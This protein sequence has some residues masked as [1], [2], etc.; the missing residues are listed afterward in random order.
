LTRFAPAAPPAIELARVTARNFIVATAGHVDH[1]K[2][3]LVKALTGADP[4]RLPEEKARG[5]TIDLGFA[6]LTLN[7][8][9]GDTLHVGIVDVPGHEDF[10]KNMIAGVGSIDLALFVIAADDGWMPQTEDHLQILTYL[11]IEHAV[12]ALTKVDLTDATKTANVRKQ[13]IDTS[14]AHAPIVETS[15]VSG[16][17]LEELRATLAC[18][19]SSLSPQHDIG[20]PRLFVDRVFSLRGVGT[21]VTGTLGGG[22]LARSQNVIVQPRNISTRIRSIQSHNREQQEIGPGT[23]TALN[24]PD[25]NRIDIARGD[26]VTISELGGPANTIDVVLKR[27]SR[28]TLKAAPIKNGASLYLH[29][30]TTR[31][32][33]RV[34]LADRR[35][36]KPSETA[37]AQ[38]Q[39]ES[40]IFAFVGDRFVLRDPSERGTLAGGVVLDVQT[41]REQFAGAK[42][43]ELL[44]ARAASP[45]DAIVAVQS[46]LQ[47]DGA[48]E[49]VDLLLRS[50]FGAREIADAVE[51]LARKGEL[52][53]HGDIV[54]DANWWMKFRRA[55]ADAIEK[56][57]E[58]HP[59]LVGLDL[60]KLRAQFT[61][62]SP[63]IFDALLVDLCQNGYAK[64]DNRIKRSE[65]RAVLPQNLTAA[66][67]KIR[68]LISE[69]PFD[70]PARK[71]LA[72]DSQSRE[73]LKFLIE[74]R[75]LIEI[76]DDL[77]LLPQH[78]DEMKE[79]VA[80][81]IA[82]SGPATVSE[83]RQALQSSRRTIVPFLEQLDRERFTHRMGDKRTLGSLR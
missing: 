29:H 67:E 35:D 70:P 39:L 60:A 50:N 17:G 11:G 27:T 63:K 59:Q 62:T 65:H 76:G 34:A 44:L 58:M 42:Q 74:Q 32:R 16:G 41:K 51:A 33:A 10:V 14:F 13:L 40:P 68:S 49:H 36:L 6:E 72:A 78:F 82:K 66:A 1:G 2:S 19:L 52:V 56:E 57:H 83:L 79:A 46:E 15:I 22:K 5:I 20:K 12:I 77:V 26:V 25:L 37:F 3:A 71:Q 7:N 81:F 53:V 43:R 24:L 48:K 38:L 23:R 47:R 64:I 31:V 55:A 80:E 75:E 54:A 30:G 28:L 61:E 21:I 18:E 45:N 8:G 4:D 73:T 69:K 9:Q